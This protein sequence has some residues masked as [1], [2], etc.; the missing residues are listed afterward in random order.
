MPS[1]VPSHDVENL[2]KSC[3]CMMQGTTGHSF[4]SKPRRLQRHSQLGST[5]LASCISRRLMMPAMTSSLFSRCAV[6]WAAPKSVN[7][8]ANICIGAHTGLHVAAHATCGP[9]CLLLLLQLVRSISTAAAPLS[10]Q[11]AVWLWRS[12]VGAMHVDLP[13]TT[14]AAAI[15]GIRCIYMHRKLMYQQSQALEFRCTEKLCSTSSKTL[16]Y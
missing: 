4:T 15:R 5:T 3:V 10:Q 2:C 6:T 12:G 14:E 9:G 16:R 1:R 8:T 13:S 11:Q 7:T